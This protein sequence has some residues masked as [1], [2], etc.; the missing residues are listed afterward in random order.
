MHLAILTLP[1]LRLRV[2]AFLDHSP[3]LTPV[4]NITALIRSCAPHRPRRLT[5]PPPV[6]VMAITK[7]IILPVRGNYAV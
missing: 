7:V 6:F 2:L 3:R 5:C 1:L 4:V